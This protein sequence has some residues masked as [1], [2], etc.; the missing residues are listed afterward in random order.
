MTWTLESRLEPSLPTDPGRDYCL[1]PY[2]RPQPASQ[3]ALRS[4]ALL[5]HSFAMAGVSER[6][7]AFCDR[8]LARAGRFNTVWGVKC[9]GGRLSWEFYFY[10]YRRMDRAF[11]TRAFID[12]TR[13]L[14]TVTVPA[15]DDTPYFMYSV[16]IESRH[17][18]DGHPV[19][20]LDLYI[21]NPGSAVSSGICYGHSQ[22]GMELRNFYFFFDAKR[23]AGDIREKIVSNAHVPWPRLKL[24]QILW[25]EMSAQTIVV[26]NKRMNDGLYF[27]RI[28]VGDL[29]HFMQ[30]LNFPPSLTEFARENQARLAHH[31]WD[32]GYDYLPGAKGLDY[33]KGSYYGIL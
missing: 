3:D 14:L 23:H 18:D 5:Y 9:A 1:W 30:K 31:L 13:D 28:P 32:V 33:L 27:S 25:P 15:A 4:S 24:D 8:L 29:I 20:Q 19:D 10:D 7:L 26:A 21:G 6:M 22:K 2:E 11:S 12:A 17:L 16:E